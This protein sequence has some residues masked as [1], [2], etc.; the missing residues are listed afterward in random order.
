MTKSLKEQLKNLIISRGEVSYGELVTFALEEGYKPDN[1]TRRMRELCAEENI[2]P[3]KKKS[4]R[5]TNYVYAY[6]A[7]E[8]EKKIV[9]FEIKGNIATPIYG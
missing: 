8:K 1:M 9:R 3:L 5:N 6:R 2:T 7:G 4:K